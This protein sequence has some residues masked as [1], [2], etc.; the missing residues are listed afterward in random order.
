MRNSTNR[1]GRVLLRQR[2][3]SQGGKSITS[4]YYERRLQFFCGTGQRKNKP[5]GIDGSQG[6]FRGGQTIRGSIK[7]NQRCRK[8]L[9]CTRG[10][11][12]GKQHGG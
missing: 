10:S 11:R 8:R 3:L 5:K 6:G 1:E 7:T 12:E 2:K 9:S 4:A